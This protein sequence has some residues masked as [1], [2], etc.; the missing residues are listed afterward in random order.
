MKNL[1]SI[2][3]LSVFP[4]GLLG[5]SFETFYE[6]GS[7]KMMGETSNLQDVDGWFLGKWKGFSKDGEVTNEG[8]YK[9]SIEKYKIYNEKER[10]IR[11]GRA[12]D[13][14]AEGEWVYYFD[15]GAIKAKGTVIKDKK[16]GLWTS[17]YEDGSLYAEFNYLLNKIEGR[18]KTYH[19]NGALC[20]NNLFKNSKLIGSAKKFYNNGQIE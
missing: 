16:H 12:I 7:L 20:S 5:E 9:Y 3:I 8:S 10:L 1:L 18:A 2:L 11:E 19:R 4:F 13:G 17:Y 14:L 15:N 6:E